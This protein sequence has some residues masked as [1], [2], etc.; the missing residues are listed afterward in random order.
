[1]N[2]EVMSLDAIADS[3]IVNAEVIARRELRML[4][5]ASSSKPPCQSR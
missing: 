5:S 1:M 4:R 2:D 3:N